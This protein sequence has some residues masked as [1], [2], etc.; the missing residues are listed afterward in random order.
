MKYL[1]RTSVYGFG[2]DYLTRWNVAAGGIA[3]NFLRGY[4]PRL[5]KIVSRSL[6]VEVFILT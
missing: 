5:K 6:R 4:F 1:I 2:N 3:W